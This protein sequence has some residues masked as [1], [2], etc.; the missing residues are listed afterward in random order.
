MKAILGSYLIATYKAHTYTTDAMHMVL[1]HTSFLGHA[2]GRK[3]PGDEAKTMP[4]S[5]VYDTVP[6]E[7]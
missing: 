7:M 6:Q 1:D 4:C 5:Y 3:W 2:G